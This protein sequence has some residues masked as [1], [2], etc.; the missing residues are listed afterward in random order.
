MATIQERTGKDGAISYRAMVR[1]KGFP[2]ETATFPRLTDARNWARDKEADMRN[3]RYFKTSEAKRHTLEEAID[4]YIEDVLPSKAQN[5]RHSQEAQLKWWKKRLGHLTL[6]DITAPLIAEA[7]DALAKEKT[8]F[9]KPFSPSTVVRYLAVLSHV[10]SVAIKEWEWMEFNPCQKVSK[11]K[12]PRGRVRY[13][14]DDERKR[15]LVACK[16]SRNPILHDVVLLAMTSGARKS[17]LM[18]IK[19]EDVDFQNR[20]ITIHDTKNGE[21]RGIPLVGPAFDCLLE[22]SKVRRIDSPYVFPSP[23]RRKGKPKPYDIQSAFNH[24]VKKEAKLTDFRFHDLRHTAATYLAQ[25]GATPA[26]IS[27]FLG[28]KTLQMVKRY[29]HLSQEHTVR[30]AER[31]AGR[32]FSPKPDEGASNA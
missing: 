10:F 27:E 1:M 12:E 11:P 23:H 19:W 28:H 7:R 17:E 20:T 30:V 2:L 14:N 6:A 32:I 18:N 24:A 16:K 5:S 15:L 21:R 9:K 4:R 29:A 22:R 25:T 3:G 8:R 26:E 31:M 13:L